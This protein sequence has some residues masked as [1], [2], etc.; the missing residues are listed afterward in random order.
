MHLVEVDSPK[1]VKVFHKIPF[2]IYKD[3]P[4]W[5]P[6]L[7]QDIEKVFDPEQNKLWRHGEA[8]RWI[9]LNEREE[10][11][12]RVAAFV[13]KKKKEG[14]LGFFECINDQE[15]ADR[16]FDRCKEWIEERGM[17]YMDGPINFGEKDKFWGLITENFDRPPYYGQNYNPPY[18]IDLFEQY[19]FQVYY[20]Q[21]IFHR[22]IRDPLQEKYRVRA[23][24]IEQNPKYTFQNIDMKQAE[25][26]AEDFRTVYNRAW[27]THAGFR[28]M[29]R[30]QAMSILKNMKPVMDEKLITFA[31]YEDRPIAFH[32]FLPE[33]NE[34]FQH[35][36]GNLNWWGKL[37]F[38]YYKWRGV[39]NT[40]FGV[41]F[42]VDPDHQGKGLEGALFHQM[43][44]NLHNPQHIDDY[45]DLIITW[46]GDFNPKMIRIIENL[47]AQQIREMATYRKLFDETKAFERAPI[48]Q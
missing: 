24:R 5:I 9:L 17:E 21:L 33:L 37:K 15:A 11:I 18:Y 40:C 47:G 1:K 43:E 12:G 41:A 26:F 10:P 48:I 42:G 29:P 30:I 8:T 44:K 23:E 16:L 35:V 34:I 25:K 36:N 39:C 4:N 22:K 46:I 32:V 45:E 13:N 6:H 20:K 28:E 38:L 27:K 3:D 7:K 31:Y 19:G 14:G 2:R